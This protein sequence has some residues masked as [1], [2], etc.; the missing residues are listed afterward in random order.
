LLHAV[1]AA[2][3]AL[4]RGS[5]LEEGSNACESTIMLDT[6]IGSSGIGQVVD[7]TAALNHSLS[8]GEVGRQGSE[9]RHSL[10]IDTGVRSNDDGQA[11]TAAAPPRHKS[12]RRRKGV[13]IRCNHAGCRESRVRLFSSSVYALER[14]SQTPPTAHRIITSCTPIQSMPIASPSMIPCT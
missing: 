13:S 6:P 10:T 9:G 1:G 7:S 3:L 12:A 14:T 4:P 2:E 11:V 5:S 8:V